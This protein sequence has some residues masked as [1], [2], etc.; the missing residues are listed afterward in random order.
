[1]LHVRFR[2]TLLREVMSRRQKK[3]AKVDEAA[4]LGPEYLHGL[5]K[6]LCQEALS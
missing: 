1:M 2:L 5:S 6:L 4:Y 3:E